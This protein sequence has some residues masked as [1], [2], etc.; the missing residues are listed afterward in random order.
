MQTIP[1]LK[2]DVLER[3]TRVWSARFAGV[4]A[5]D[6]ENNAKLL[7]E[8]AMVFELKDRSAQFHTNPSRSQSKQGKFVV[9]TDRLATL[10]LNLKVK[11][12]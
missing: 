5:T 6:N 12:I 1:G 3:F 7:H 9:E 4:G 11:W 2:V 10:T 8:L